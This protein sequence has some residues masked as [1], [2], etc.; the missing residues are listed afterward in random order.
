MRSELAKR[1]VGD[2]DRIGIDRDV[3]SWISGW[4]ERPR[5]FLRPRHPD[6]DDVHAP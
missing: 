1:L 4:A 6:A 3:A 2:V 5:S